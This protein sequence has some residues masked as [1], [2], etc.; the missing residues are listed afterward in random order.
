MNSSYP[1]LV[2]DEM[3]T[4]LICLSFFHFDLQH[5]F[6]SVCLA[7]PDLDAGS[8]DAF[9][10]DHKK[11]ALSFHSAVLNI[12]D[13]RVYAF[14]DFSGGEIEQHRFRRTQTEQQPFRNGDFIKSPAQIHA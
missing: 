5:A 7:V 2:F 10:F 3:K 13:S 4:D 1:S 11:A 14:H 6:E 12:G 8:S 9:S